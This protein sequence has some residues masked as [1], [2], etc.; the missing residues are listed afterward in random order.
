G[1]GVI[2][3]DKEAVKWYRLAAGQEDAYAQSKL[4]WI[5]FFG[6]RVP[7]DFEEAFKWFQLAAEQGHAEARHKLILMYQNG[8]GILQADK[9]K[10]KRDQLAAEQGNATA[11]FN[12]GVR[13][14]KGK[15]VLRDY[16]EAEKWYRLAAEQGFES[17]QI[18]LGVMYA[19]GEGVQKDHKEAAKWYQ[20]AAEHRFHPFEQGDASVQY[21]LGYMYAN[22]QGVIQNDKEA[23][24]WY[25]LAAEQEHARAQFRLGLMYENGWGVPQDFVLALMWFN[26]SGTNGEESGTNLRKILGRWVTPQQSIKAREM[27]ENWRPKNSRMAIKQV[28]LSEDGKKTIEKTVSVQKQA[29]NLISK[30]KTQT[31]SNSQ[32][33]KESD[34]KFAAEYHNNYYDP[35]EAYAFGLKIQ[36]AVKDRNLKKLFSFVVDGELGTGPRRKYVEGKTFSEIFPDDWRKQ[37]L[38]SKPKCSPLGWKPF[39]LA[40]GTIWYNKFKNDNKD[41]GRARCVGDKR[42][43]SLCHW[44]I[45]AID[46]AMEEKF[47]KKDLPVGWKVSG[48]HIPPQCF[49]KEWYSSDNYEEF[50]KQYQIENYDDFRKNPGKYLG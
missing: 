27:A 15:G 18:N 4:G 43:P 44:S 49:V 40:N 46:G 6:K 35:E 25:R 16:K 39:M 14:S 26:L 50:E 36:N 21:I 38:S 10:A 22:G 20:L 19:Q 28:E 13:Y 32:V 41:E 1:Q 30:K 8:Q 42:N 17:A 9:D 24:K 29:L 33:C 2:Q 12:L 3:N 37:I 11:Q 47:E 7:Q 31:A 23:V 5:Y 34:R 45:I 48:E